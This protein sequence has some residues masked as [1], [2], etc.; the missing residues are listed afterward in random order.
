VIVAAHQPNFLPYLG[1][2]DKMSKCDIFV[3]RDDVDFSKSDF[4]HR[5]RIRCNSHDNIACPKFTW[6]NLN[7]EKKGKI[8]NIKIKNKNCFE[9]IIDKINKNYK[10]SKYFKEFN[11]ELQYTLLKNTDKLSELNINIVYF[12]KKI[13]NIKCEIKLASDIKL[14]GQSKSKDLAELCSYFGA[15]TYLSGDGA[16]AYINIEEF[17]HIRVL[18][19]EF[20]HPIYEQNYEGFISNMSFIDHLFCH[21]I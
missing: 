21:G 7:V 3:I 1:F 18:F 5:N 4:H 12:I 14:S 6:I 19:Q 8:K 20:K 9:E 15:H 13:Y 11:N 16:K 10:N 2:L 17:G